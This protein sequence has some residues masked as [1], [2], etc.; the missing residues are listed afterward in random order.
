[1][2]TCVPFIAIPLQAGPIPPLKR[3]LWGLHYDDDNEKLEIVV[4]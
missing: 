1:M 4:R 3:G 2:N